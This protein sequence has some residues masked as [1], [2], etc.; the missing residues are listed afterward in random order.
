MCELKNYNS[1]REKPATVC[2]E[3][4]SLHEQHA[5]AEYSSQNVYELNIELTVLE[6]DLYNSIICIPSHCF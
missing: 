3:R 6:I 5:E 4:V 1:V 2:D